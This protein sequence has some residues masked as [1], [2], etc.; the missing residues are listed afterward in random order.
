MGGRGASSGVSDKGHV[1]GTEYFSIYKSGNIKFVKR[2]EGSASTPMET[3]TSNRVYVTVNNKNELKSV[4]YYNRDNKRVKQ[5]DLT[6]HHGGKKP[7]V[8][9]GYEHDEYGTRG[10]LPKEKKMVDKV[11]KLWNTFNK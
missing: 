5:I 2:R 4:T 11:I 9:R 3:M 7:H 10:L 6:H 8:H 1:Y